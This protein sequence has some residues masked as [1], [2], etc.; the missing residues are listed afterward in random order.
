MNTEQIETL[1]K[2]VLAGGHI[3]QEEALALSES[4]EKEALYAAAD[5]IRA[6]F[7]GNRIDM[8]SIMNA[9]SGRCSEDCKW[10]SQSRHFKT[11]VPE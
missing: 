8:C 1:K 5:Q 9:Q 4:N 11:G 6:H 3:T 7:M 2:R 10:C